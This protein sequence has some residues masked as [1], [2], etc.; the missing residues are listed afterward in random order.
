MSCLVILDVAAQP[1]VPRALAR[2]YRPKDCAAFAAQI[3]LPRVPN[4][5]SRGATPRNI[6]SSLL[7][8]GIAPSRWPR[9]VT[10]NSN[11]ESTRIEQPARLMP[12]IEQ[13]KDGD[14]KQAGAECGW[15]YYFVLAAQ[16]R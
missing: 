9:V 5:C 12:G 8:S 6:T 11:K 4:F 10:A 7:Q 13:A 16:G 15:R 2:S 14:I 1:I 3:A